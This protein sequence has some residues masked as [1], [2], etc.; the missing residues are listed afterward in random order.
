MTTFQD[1]RAFL[2][3]HRTDYDAAVRDFRWPDP[4]PFNWALDWF[5]AELADNAD[6]KD[7]P[8]LWIVD[9]GSNRETKLS[10]EALSRRSNQVANFLRAQGLKRGDHL[11]LLL[12]NVIP[13]WETML[14]AM[15][16][17]VVVIPATTLLTPDELRDRLDRGRAKIVV[18]TQDQVAKFAGL[19]GD[20]L[21]RVVVGASS[22]QE[23]W[24]PYEQAADFPEA[25]TPDGPTKPDDPMLLYFTSGTTAKPKLVRH[26]QRSYP[27]GG[28][29]TMYWLGLQPGDVH[30]NIS[31]P[32]WAKHAWSCLFAP[33][34]A[35]ATVFV[36][37]QPRFDAKGLLATIGR[38]GVTTLCAPPTVWRLFIQEQLATFKVSLREVCGAGE[39]L[40]PE[41]IDQVRMAWGL[42]IRDGYGQTETTA[43][44]GNSPGQKVK[45]GSMGRP[46]PGYRVQITDVDGQVTK[47]GEVTLEL[48]DERPAGLMQGYQG[49]DGKLSGADGDLYRSGDVVFAD[50]EGYLTFVG[51]SDDVFKSSDYRISPFELESILLEHES[52][53]EAAVVPSPD[54]I[55]LAIPKAY[56]LLVAGKERSA[57]TALSIFRHLHTRLAPF[58]RIRRIELVTE[59]PKTIS[60]KIRRVQLRRLEHDN[61]RE[62]SLRGVEFRE[63]DFP[64]LKKVMPAGS[65]E[66]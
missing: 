53:A 2:L 17:G 43:L 46:L 5:D 7:R 8:A 34:N 56:V 64:E 54:P 36:V 29:S 32:G 35:G 13:L 39:P 55:R 26:S 60:G 18:A 19:G 21:I 59:L 48:G 41:V 11:L 58:K 51:R 33:W 62:D 63:E 3:Q 6:S 37:N 57:E 24:L 61:D 49:D 42:T 31:S 44:A 50:D 12:G 22:K 4:V 25:F 23:G 38:C 16:L 28:L 15:K 1:A 14:A 27:V 65:A 40:N 30:L 66:N 45:V 47:E 20:K 10:F 9:A 52:V